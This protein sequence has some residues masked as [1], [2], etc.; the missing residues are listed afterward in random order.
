MMKYGDNQWGIEQLEFLN[1]LK[2]KLDVTP[3]AP[4]FSYVSVRCYKSWVCYVR[5][6]SL[7]FQ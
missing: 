6:I 3:E 2:E 4:K 5:Q 1:A 7:G